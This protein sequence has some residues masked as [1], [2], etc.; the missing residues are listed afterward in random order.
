MSGFLLDQYP[1]STVVK[2]LFNTYNAAGASV[3]TT[4]LAAADI[5]IYKD[6]STTQR[7]SD[8]GFT[9]D[10]DFDAL[11]GIHL[12]SIDLADNT[13]AGFYTVGSQF[14]VVVST[15]TVDAQTVSLVLGS[16]RIM[17]AEHTTGHPVITIKDGTGTGELDT[18][19]G[20][21]IVSSIAAGAITAAAIATGAIDADAIADNAIDA[22]AIAADAITAAKIADGAIDAAT[23]AAGAIN[24]A[25]IA[26]GAIDADALAADAGT[27]IATAV[28]ASGTR[29]LTALDEDTTT[30]DIDGALAAG[31]PTAGAI[32]DAVWDEALAGH[33]GAGSAGEALDA[34]G[35]AGDPWLTALPG[36]Y[37]AGT[38]GFIVGT[39]LDATVSS[40]ASQT[41]VNTIDDFLDTEI[42]AL[43]TAVADLPT[44]A[45]LATALGTADD[46]TLAAI[47]ALETK[48]DTID[49]IIDT[50]VPAIKAKTDQLT[51]TVA[52]VVDTNIEYVNA[53]QVQG[54]GAGGDEW[55][56]V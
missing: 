37:G 48:V 41:S 43:T 53:T 11:T 15:I 10:D 36:A 49:N 56:P 45:E 6:G 16:F 27:E 7:A 3:T 38:A 1:A 5:E 2:A 47:A 12:I 33:Q 34:A 20:G 23:F 9:V 14:S 42:A 30:I 31:V 54:T 8:A 52:N 55:R 46:A 25:A 13:D 44:N 18:T 39:N 17:A 35:T 26:T 22:G 32:A 29:T 50:E 21:V 40:R 19:S 28:W 24:A 4:G 51:F